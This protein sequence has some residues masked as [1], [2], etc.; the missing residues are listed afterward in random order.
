MFSSLRKLAAALLLV[1]GSSLPSSAAPTASA[2]VGGFQSDLVAVM[3]EAKNLSP[4]AR[5]D[6]L[7]PSIDRT[8]HVHTMIRVILGPL[9]GQTPP[10]ERER[11]TAAFRRMSIATVATLFDGYSGETFSVVAEGQGPQET[12]LVQTHLK[13]SDGDVIDIAYFGKSFKGEWRIVD[14]IVDKGISE[15]TV[16]RSEYKS[17]LESG[18]VAGL[19]DVLNKKADSLLAQ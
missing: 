5:F 17:I 13:K 10:E 1:A 3:K 9:W 6:R 18:G 7:A 16:R 4:K 14:V 11:L 15:L 8:F 19:V 12:T 2:V